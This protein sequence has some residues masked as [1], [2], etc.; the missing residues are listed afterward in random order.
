MTE[1]HN[2]SGAGKAMAIQIHDL[3]ERMLQLFGT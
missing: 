3:R 2:Y 1:A